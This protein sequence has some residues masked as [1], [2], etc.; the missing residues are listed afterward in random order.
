MSSPPPVCSSLPP[1]HRRLPLHA[2]RPAAPP[3]G[4]PSPPLRVPLSF[5]DADWLHTK[6]KRLVRWDA[7]A[8]T[9]S[10]SPPPH[11]PLQPL[12]SPPLTIASFTAAT[13]P[14]S[15]SPC[16]R[17]RRMWGDSAPMVEDRGREEGARQRRIARRSGR[18]R[19]GEPV[20]ERLST[21]RRR[22]GEG[23]ETTVAPLAEGSSMH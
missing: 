20:A 12:R 5:F 14:A 17:G 16:G 19:V 9:A 8:A 18:S 6:A 23:H 7:M 1:A 4:P 2:V 13:V 10:H 21:R 11:P 22:Q 15:C 3:W